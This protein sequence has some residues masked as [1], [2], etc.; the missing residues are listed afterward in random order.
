MYGVIVTSLNVRV[1][2]YTAAKH[3]VIGLTKA[4]ALTYS[5]RR[6]INSTSV[7]SLVPGR[8]VCRAAASVVRGGKLGVSAPPRLTGTRSLIMGSSVKTLK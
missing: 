4:D 5:L 7:F 6:D 2:S 3:G 8:F 1:V